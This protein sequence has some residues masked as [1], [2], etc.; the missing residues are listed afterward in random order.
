MEKCGR[1]QNFGNSNN[2]CVMPILGVKLFTLWDFLSARGENVILRW[3]RDERLS[4]RDRAA[5]N[6]RFDRLTQIDFQLAVD[7]F[8]AG[9]IYRQVYKLIIHA[10]VMLRPMLC[11]GPIEN[12]T[13]YTLL[14]GAIE[15]NRRLPPGAKEEAQANCE[16]V[17]R[18]PSRRERHARIPATRGEDRVPGE[19]EGTAGNAEEGV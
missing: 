14:L 2:A 15:R 5:L 8:L 3:V 6:Q 11:R 12:E 1:F 16:T 7:T 13:E 9:P 19:N 4:K 17:I 10:D 18:D